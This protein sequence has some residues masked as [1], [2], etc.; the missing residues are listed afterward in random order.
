MH[1]LWEAISF[2]LT[3]VFSGIYCVWF[4]VFGIGLHIDVIE[5]YN[6]KL[7]KWLLVLWYLTAGIPALGF[8]IY[9][10]LRGGH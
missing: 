2:V 8:L 3:V 6:D 9:F 7:A 10:L 1:Y 4:F 5:N